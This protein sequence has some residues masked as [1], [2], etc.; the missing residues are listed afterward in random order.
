[1]KIDDREQIMLI[2][3]TGS[4]PKTFHTREEEEGELMVISDT[5]TVTKGGFGLWRLCLR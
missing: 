3:D 4:R 5:V 1:M 2:R